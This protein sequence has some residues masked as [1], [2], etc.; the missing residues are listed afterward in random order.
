M[1][2]KVFT[3]VSLKHTLLRSSDSLSELRRVVYKKKFDKYFLKH[4]ELREELILSY[5]VAGTQIEIRHRVEIC[6]D[7]KD[8][9]YLELAI[10]GNADLIISGDSDLTVLNPFKGIPIIKPAE[11]L[12]LYQ[13]E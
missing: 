4:P 6:R 1:T 5:L 2:L 7:R 10:S 3:I 13:N 11:F 8:N 12:N 9:L